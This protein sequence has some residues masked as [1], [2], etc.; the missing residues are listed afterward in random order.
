MPKMSFKK[1]FAMMQ[2]KV[3]VERIKPTLRGIYDHP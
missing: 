1:A 3:R 2:K